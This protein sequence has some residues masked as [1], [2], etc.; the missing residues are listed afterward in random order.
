MIELFQRE[1]ECCGCTGCVSACS[2]NAI[3]MKMNKKGFLYPE[4]DRELCIECGLCNLV[5]DFKKFDASC[6]KPVSY[7]VRHKNPHEVKTSRSGAFFMVLCKKIIGSGGVVFGCR[8]TDGC[9]AVHSAAKTYEECK[10]FKGS[11]YVQSDMGQCFSECKGYLETG[12]PVLF[13]GTGC[14]V[15]GLLRYLNTFKVP[16]DKL[17]TVDIVCHGV[18]SPGVWAEYLSEL[19]NRVGGGIRHVDFRDKSI[20]G[21]ADHIES[22]DLDNGRKITGKNWT[23]IFYRHVM[24]RDSCYKCKYTTTERYSDFT[25]AD[26]WNIGNNAP[27]FDDNKGVSLVM[28]HSEKGKMLFKELAESFDFEKTSLKTSMQ[29][30]MLRPIWKG[31]DYGVFWKLYQKNPQ[32]AVRLYFFPNLLTRLIWRCE[33]KGKNIIKK[34]LKK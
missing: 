32:N 20:N 4:I 31:W 24:F 33:R 6:K 16:T 17:I 9:K 26:Y 1:D 19:C 2:K 34:I 15:H 21:W 14:Q 7:A 22:Y 8:L 29:P 3:S 18:P 5:C 10:F 28:V 25:I 12:I 27:R 23:N 30:Q 13:S 11:K